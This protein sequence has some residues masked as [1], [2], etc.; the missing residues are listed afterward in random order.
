MRRVRGVAAIALASGLAWDV[1]PPP[2][3][4]C[5]GDSITHYI[6]WTLG[7]DVTTPKGP[8]KWDPAEIGDLVNSQIFRCRPGG[9]QMGG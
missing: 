3:V 8:R 5:V 7:T 9:L 6:P 2:R 1:Q 4:W